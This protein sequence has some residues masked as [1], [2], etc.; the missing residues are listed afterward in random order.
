M[1]KTEI[2][3]TYVE[4]WLK[5]D[6]TQFLTI[7]SKDIVITECY[8]PQYQ[9]KKECQKWFLDWTKPFD[10]SVRNWTVKESYFDGATGFFTWT[11]DD[12]YQ[13]KSGLFDGISLVKFD[14]NFISE[15]Q[16]FEMKHEKRR[17]YKEEK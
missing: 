11:F 17:P 3:E 12:I 4:A 15:I 7:L 10:N 16:E 6:L 8:G 14:G 2:F 1:I 13:G 9:G 5:K